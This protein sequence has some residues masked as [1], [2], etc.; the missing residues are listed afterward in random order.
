MPANHENDRRDAE[1]YRYLRRVGV[2]LDFAQI[3]PWKFDEAV[4]TAVDKWLGD[5]EPR[6]PEPQYE[7]R[8]AGASWDGKIMYVRVS[9]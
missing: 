2:V 9:K 3:A 8:E 5:F 4:D 6:S 1:R 7:Y